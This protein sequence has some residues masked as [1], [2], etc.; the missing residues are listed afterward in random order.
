MSIIVDSNV[1]LDIFTVD[2]NWYEWSSN[3]LMEYA[4]DSVLI[5]Y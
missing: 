4:E 2:K 1:I 3:K 5:K